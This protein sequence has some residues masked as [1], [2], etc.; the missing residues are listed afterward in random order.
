MST[1]AAE[2]GNF[3]SQVSGKINELKDEAVE[4]IK[5]ETGEG[6]ALEGVK[7]KVE[8]TFESVKGKLEHHA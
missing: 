8:G 1:D 3:L 4:T 6:G 2:G 7:E 5:K